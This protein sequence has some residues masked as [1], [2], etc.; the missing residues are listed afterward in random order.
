MLADETNEYELT[1]S[2]IESPCLPFAWQTQARGN[3]SHP[4]CTVEPL[5]CN[6][7]AKISAINNIQ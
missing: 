4:W 6:Q 2:K 7:E 3:S 1:E 5:F